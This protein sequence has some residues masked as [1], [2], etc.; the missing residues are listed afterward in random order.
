[1][2]GPFL[3][4][5]ASGWFGRTALHVYEQAHGPEALR[6]E[7]I[8]FASRER[9]VDFGSPHGPVLAKPLAE[10]TEVSDPAGLLHLAF[11][12][13]DKA[14]ELG[15]ETYV[16]SNRAI[17]A[18]VGLLLQAWPAMPVVTTSSG[19][20]AALDGQPPDLDGN[21][22]ASL[23]QE[24]EA[25]LERE[26]SSRMA[27]VFRVFAASGQFMTRPQKFA[28]GDFLLQAMAGEAIRIR[29]CHR[30]TRSYVSV[31]TLMALSWQL[32]QQ[33]DTP[34]CLQR[35]DACT[36]TLA[37]QELAQLVAA[38][39]GVD[40]ISPE[41]PPA[42]AHDNYQGDLTRFL[43]LLSRRQLQ[44]STLAEQ[45]RLTLTGLRERTRDVG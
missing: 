10:I 42:A 41:I 14:A 17:T 6:R 2:S 30:V 38:E 33:P 25:L 35:I 40:V 18:T 43:S 22:Y 26:A 15:L 7:V 16:A 32:L 34:S 3:L 21:P 5:G 31:E 36:D 1:L 4:T 44:P 45:I 12:T 9:W 20:A 19:A 28:L 23:K 37:L 39:T 24:E 29:A 8:P 11:L 13:R 27:M